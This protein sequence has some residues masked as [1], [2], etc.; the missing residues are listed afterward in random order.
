MKALLNLGVS[1]SDFSAAARPTMR[2]D[3]ASASPMSK[4][5][6]WTAGCPQ[7][8][9]EDVDSAFVRGSSIDRLQHAQEGVS[10]ERTSR[11]R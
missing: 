1:S 5:E 10:F 9:R 4:A 7:S 2:P 11:A 3:F 8:Q 6:H